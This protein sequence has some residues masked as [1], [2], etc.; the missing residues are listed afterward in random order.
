MLHGVATLAEGLDEKIDIYHGE[1]LQQAVGLQ[2]D[3]APMYEDFNARKRPYS[4]WMAS[5][6]WRCFGAQELVSGG[7]GGYTAE[8]FHL[9]EEVGFS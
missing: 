6:G 4:E 1:S 7:I 8:C 9:P 5:L 3:A 2:K